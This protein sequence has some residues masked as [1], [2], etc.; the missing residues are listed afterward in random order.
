MY[1][2]FVILDSSPSSALLDHSSVSGHRIN[3]SE[4]PALPTLSPGHVY[5]FFQ[6]YISGFAATFLKE[7]LSRWILLFQDGVCRPNIKLTEQQV[8]CCIRKTYRISHTNVFCNDSLPRPRNALRQWS[9]IFKMWCTPY[10]Y[11]SICT[12]L[13]LL[14]K[15][16]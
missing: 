12:T 13:M 11:G 7:R 4:L 16:F 3:N 1:F 14:L 6:V 10:R 5:N 2:L 9:V 8:I 15:L